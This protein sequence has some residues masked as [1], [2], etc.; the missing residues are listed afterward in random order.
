MAIAEEEARLAEE[1]LRAER[2]RAALQKEISRY[3]G[4]GYRVVSQSDYAAQLV[5]PKVF[6]RL[7]A[8]LW[9]LAFGVGLIVYL[10]W[11]WAKRDKQLY[12]TVDEA[13]KVH[14]K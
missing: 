5:K 11:Y 9:F 2:R 3:V 10:L 7:W 8:F 14:K 1:R 13:G 12:L 6:S 4:Q